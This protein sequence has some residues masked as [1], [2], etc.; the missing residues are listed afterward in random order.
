[1]ALL[2]GTNSWETV[3]E[4]DTYLGDRVD[5]TGWFD[6][7]D[8]AE[9]AGGGS[10]ESY[11]VT[12]FRWLRNTRQ[13]TLSDSLTDQVVKD[14]QSEAALFLISYQDEYEDREAAI[15]SGVKSFGVSKRRES[16]EELVLPQRILD[17]L[18][19]FMGGLNFVELTGEF[20]V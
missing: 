8:I 11:L 5:S 20:D 18:Q 10:K 4:A 12:A 9:K 2:V 7:A 14:A 3:A 1:M 19:A 13:L 16:L 6:L 17:T 15:A